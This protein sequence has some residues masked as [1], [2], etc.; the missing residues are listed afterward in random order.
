MNGVSLM[1]TTLWPLQVEAASSVF[2]CDVVFT[3]PPAASLV[4]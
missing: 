3:I 4:D 2:L 1:L